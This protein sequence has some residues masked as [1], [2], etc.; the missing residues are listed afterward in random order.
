MIKFKD[1]SSWPLKQIYRP[2][3]KLAED[4]WL[5]DEPKYR[6]KGGTQ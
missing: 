6:N 1:L 3:V 4:V 2:F 5:R